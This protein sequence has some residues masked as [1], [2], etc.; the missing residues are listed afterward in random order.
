MKRAI[1]VIALVVVILVSAGAVYTIGPF[2]SVFT[3]TQTTTSFS[4]QT[5]YSSSSSSTFSTLAIG[6][7]SDCNLSAEQ[8][9]SAL[10][11]IPASVQNSL[12]PLFPCQSQ[13]DPAFEIYPVIQMNLN[14][15][16]EIRAMYL[17]TSPQTPTNESYPQV[18]E[19]PFLSK[20][21]ATL[22]TDAIPFNLSNS[23]LITNATFVWKNNSTIEYQ[24]SI[25][26][27]SN[28][29]GYYDLVLPSSCGQLQIPLTVG[30]SKNSLSANSLGEFGY[31]GSVTCAAGV[32]GL[33]VGVGNGNVTYVMIP[34]FG[35]ND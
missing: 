11:T 22:I 31:D 6:N 17:I 12:Q 19:T 33:I 27:L 23:F 16:I 15:T 29:T 35:P 30:I 9:L 5:T 21:N 2:R 7:P 25:M 10:G 3:I 4:Q 18:Y 20:P 28:S 1:I 26:S 24:Y 14:S 8:V 32:P 34:R 13:S